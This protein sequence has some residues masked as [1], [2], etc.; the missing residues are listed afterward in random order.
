[1]EAAGLEGAALRASSQPRFR[2]LLVA[3][4]GRLVF[5]RYFGDATHETLFD[6][7]SVTKSV[8]SLLTG[9]A[10]REGS[11]PVSTPRSPT[12]WLRATRSIPRTP[13]SRCATC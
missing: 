12:G 1:M 4:H 2:S 11:S 5:E 13:R 8:A 3:R 6:V 7:R 9:I 10:L